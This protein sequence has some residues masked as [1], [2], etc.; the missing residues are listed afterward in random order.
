MVVNTGDDLELHGLLICPDLDT[1]MYTLAG[2]ANPDTGW[3]IAGDTWSG[4]AMLE[5]FG[6]ETWFRLGDA[7]LATHL[8]R[9][10]R[11]RAGQR[12]T[13]VTAALAA[14]LRVPAALLPMT[15]EPVR[16]Q[17]ATAD[18]WL[19]FQDYFVRR[20]HR[21][22]VRAIR[23][24]GIDAARATS[25]VVSA[26][27]AADLIVFAPSNPFVSIGTILA[28]PG[29]RDA[30]MASAAP[31]VAVSPIVAGAAL[32]G[33]ADAMLVSLQG[34][35][36]AH[37]VARHYATEHPGL[38]DDFV[39]DTADA[40]PKAGIEALGLRAHVAP[41]VMRTDADRESLAVAD[42]RPAA[43][44]LIVRIATAH[45]RRRPYHPTRD[46]NG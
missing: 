20:G 30:L 25:E 43:R 28:V 39:I 31:V 4:A 40:T 1:V 15:D 10:R 36:S 2:L 19:E 42:P 7:D 5:R 18:G 6:A 38:V 45:G 37:A 33:P 27:A 35:A 21:D 24:A 46:A 9:T 23:Y 17:V 32:R 41:T 44:N 22:E 29:L 11:L 16:T 34:E 12:L 13:E 8:E 26:I 14:A 3:G